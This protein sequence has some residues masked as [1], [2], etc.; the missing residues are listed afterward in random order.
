MA[1]EKDTGCKGRSARGGLGCQGGQARNT[2]SNVPRKASELGAC[3][4][5]KG[6]IFTIGLGNKGKDGDMLCMFKEKMATHIGSKCSDNAAQESTSKKRIVLA[7][8]T[9]SSAIDTRHAERV[10]PTREQLNCKMT[11]L[12]AEQN[13]ILKEI[14]IQPNNQDLMKERREIEDQILKCEIDLNSEVEMKLTDNEKMAHCNAWHSHCETTEG[15]EK[16]RGE[17]YLLLLGQFTQVLIDKM[18]QETTWV[19]VSELFDTILLIKL[20]KKLVLKQSDNLKKYARRYLY[21]TF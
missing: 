3:K 6:H 11:S 14:A 10:R 2:S 5:L 20:I 1:W 21:L 17:V 9:Y 13:E 8:P 19:M 16:S 7:E 18:N 4:D 15:L 12:V